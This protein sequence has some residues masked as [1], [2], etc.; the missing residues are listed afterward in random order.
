MASQPL[1]HPTSP[2]SACAHPIR[3]KTTSKAFADLVPHVE[4]AVTRVQR[5]IEAGHSLACG[6][7]GGKDSTVVAL[8][9]FEAM[10]RVHAAGNRQPKHYVSSANTTVE[11]PEI[12]WNLALAH[13]EIQRWVEHHELPVEVRMVEPAL[14]ARFVVTTIGRGSLPRFVANSQGKRACSWSWKLVPQQRLAKQLAAEASSRGHRETITVLGVR[15]DESQ[16]RGTAMQDRGDSASAPVRNS[17]GHLVLS[18]IAEWTETEVW[19]FLSRFLDAESAPFVSYVTPQ[20]VRRLLDLYRDANEGV[21]GI[22][23]DDGKRAPCNTRFGCWTCMATGERDRSMESLLDSDPSYAYLRGLSDFRA[24]L[25]ATQWDLSLRDLIGR[26]LSPAG[27]IPVRPDVYS[28]AQR[29]SLLEMLITLDVLEEER[30]ADHEARLVRGELPSTP[31]NERMCDP[32]FCHVGPAELAAIDF[33]WS[34]HPVA[35]EAFPALRIW[36]DVR[37]LGRKRY[38]KAVATV[39]ATPIPAKRWFY[40]GDFDAQVPADGLRDYGAELWNR[41]LHPERPLTHRMVNGERTAWFEETDGLEVDAT[42]ACLFIDRFCEGKVPLETQSLAAIESARFWLNEGIVTLPAGMA[43]RYQTMAKRGQ[44]FAHL[45]VHLNLSP[46]EMD[47]YLT[48][49]AIDDEAHDALCTQAMT[50]ASTQQPDL[51]DCLEEANA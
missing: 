3:L 34:M 31:Y 13:E 23:L 7:S 17:E 12:F 50:R 41:H 48:T 5:L 38:P 21:C 10:R 8:L 9:C 25:V 14:S 37:T 22:F 2:L 33:Y 30:A 24:Y 40:V 47:H 15:R 44:Y 39:P 4:T 18:L 49:N 27:Y 19:D 28:F 16:K 1:S 6:F 43:A 20:S 26:S 42:A 46:L 11:N 36:Y 45:L 29:R 35:Q 32:Q 51:F